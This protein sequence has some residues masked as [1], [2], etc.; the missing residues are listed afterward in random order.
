MRSHNHQPD[1]T[2]PR[3]SLS[4][5]RGVVTPLAGAY[6]RHGQV[7]AGGTGGGPG[8]TCGIG[9]NVETTD[10]QLLA[11]IACGDRAAFGAF[12]DR[13]AADV[14]GLLVKLLRIHVEAEDV[15]QEAFWQV[16]CQAG[17]YD[18]GRSS[19]RVW[20]ILIA[21]SRAMDRMRKRRREPGGA[22]EGEPTTLVDAADEIQRGEST[23]LARD[24]LARLPAEQGG[25]ISLA[26]F[27]GLTHEQIA[28]VQGVPLGTVKTRI[29][30]GMKRLREELVSSERVPA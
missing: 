26:F 8:Q 28:Q 1:L 20:L 21:R 12:Y 10:Q 11:R 6:A 15:L 2:G 29:R 9:P 25:A 19:P 16:W 5:G 3:P 24:A 13:H 7:L 22:P 27:G 14:L 18:S 23:Q 4:D 17:R 30:L